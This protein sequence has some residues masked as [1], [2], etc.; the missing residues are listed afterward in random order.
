MAHAPHEVC[1]YR[2]CIAPEHLSWATYIEQVAHQRADGTFNG[3][4][5]SDEVVRDA[6]ARVR[7][8]ERQSVVARDLGVSH[9]TIRRW[10]LGKARASALSDTAYAS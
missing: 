1:G 2:H 4:I 7:A 6:V 3:T 10:V 9:T 5:V 8:G